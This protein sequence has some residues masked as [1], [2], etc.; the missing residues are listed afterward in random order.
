MASGGKELFEGEDEI[1]G[2]DEEE[3]RHEMIP[4]QR[5]VKRQCGEKDENDQRNHLLNDLQLHQG[6]RSAVA[7]ETYTVGGDLQ[8]VLEESDSPR[9]ENNENKR[10]GVGEEPHVLE[11]QMAVPR[12]R[13]KHIRREK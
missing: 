5:H 2:G 6:E 13:H 4:P 3:A 11:L 9:E 8:A 12:K 7:L 10:C 1:D